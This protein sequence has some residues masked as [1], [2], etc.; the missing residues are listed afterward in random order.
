MRKFFA[1]FCILGL[2]ASVYAQFNW[3]LGVDFNTGL[4][5]RGVPTGDRA[6]KLL[7][8]G[9]V[10][11]ANNYINNPVDG[12][13]DYTYTPGY[14]DLFSYGS[15]KWLRGNELRL[16][17]GY[18]MEGIELHT[19][20]VLDTLVRADL[21]DGTGIPNEFG[22][23]HSLVQTPNSTRTVNWGDILRYSLEEYYYLKR[24]SIRKR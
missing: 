23:D 15:G 7:T 8:I 10:N 1:L 21:S 22:P 16:T 12:R 5:A 20:S 18:R 13:G 4:L 19:M 9:G 14:Q 3:E 24:I 2:A 11:E 17:V 6:E